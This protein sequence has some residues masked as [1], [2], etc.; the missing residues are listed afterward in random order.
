MMSFD[1]PAPGFF[2]ARLAENRHEVS[3]GIAHRSFA[4]LQFAQN[5]FEAHDRDRLGITA[6]AKTGSEERVRQISL[7]RRHFFDG[8]TFAVFGI[9]LQVPKRENS[10]HR[11]H[12]GATGPARGQGTRARN[13]GSSTR[14]DFVIANGENSAGGNGITPKIA[15]EIFSAG[16]DVIT[17]G[18]HLWDQKEVMELLA[19]RKALSASAQLSARNAGAG[20]RHL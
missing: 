1:T 16:V 10:F 7:R 13:C 20:E 9:K 19:K 11:R 18:D 14:L 17:S 3:L 8:K 12:R 5:I 6:L 15:E 4:L 2:V